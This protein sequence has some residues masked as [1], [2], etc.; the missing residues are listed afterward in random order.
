MVCA[1]PEDIKPQS[2]VSLTLFDCYRVKIFA[3]P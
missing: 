3:I 2:V 1:A